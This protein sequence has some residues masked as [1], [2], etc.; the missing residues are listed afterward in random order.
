[1]CDVE[2]G[3][4]NN[5]GRL[6]TPSEEI[7]YTASHYWTGGHKRGSNQA[8]TKPDSAQVSFTLSFFILF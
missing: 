6:P 4:D 7:F 8:R 1:M 2:D 3:P 5:T